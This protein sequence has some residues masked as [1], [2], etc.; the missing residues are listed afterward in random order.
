[1]SN[2]KVAVIT[3]MYNA[4]PFIKR[5]IQSVQKQTYTDW[6]MYVVNDCSTDDSVKV[7]EEIMKTETRVHLLNMDVNSGPAKCRT[8]GMLETKARYIAFLDADDI[9]LPQK[10]EKQINLM[11]KNDLGLVYSFY[12]CIDAND[13]ETGKIITAPTKLTFHDL[14]KY[15]YVGCL[16]AL[17]DTEKVG[18]PI[19]TPIYRLHDYLVWLE[20]ASQNVR[21]VAV[22]EVLASYRIGL[23]SVSKNKWKASKYYWHAMRRYGKFN[24]FKSL[25][26]YLRYFIIGLKRS[27]SFKL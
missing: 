9:W 16:T 20:I 24:L 14:I 26:F 15:N 11:K 7:V 12:N 27:G 22:P 1:M 23:S 21:I 2:Q 4:E 6:E 19:P 13:I 10:L 8:K 17:F 25:F 18:K 5:T 3:A